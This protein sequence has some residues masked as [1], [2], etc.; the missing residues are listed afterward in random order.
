MIDQGIAST[1]P[2]RHDTAGSEAFGD[3]NTVLIVED[4]ELNMKL[5]NDVLLAQGYNVLK[6]YN[7]QDGFNMER[8][9]HPD[10][11][12]MDIHLPGISGLEVTKWIKRD[13]DLKSIPVVAITAYAMKGDEAKIRAGGCESYLA[14]PITVK[15]LIDLVARYTSPPAAA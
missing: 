13:E 5:F 14:K 10:L 6:A 3:R 12:L 7:G 1:L 8:E 2:Q 4:N 9:H 15:D 11:V